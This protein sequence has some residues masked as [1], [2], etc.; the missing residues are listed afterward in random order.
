MYFKITIINWLCWHTWHT[1]LKIVIFFKTKNLARNV[2]LFSIFTTLFNV[3]LNRRQLYFPICS[4][5]QSVLI[6]H[7]MQSLEKST[8]TPAREWKR[9]G[10]IMSSIIVKIVLTC[11]L[12][13]MVF[14]R[15]S[16]GPWNILWEFL[17]EISSKEFVLC[18]KQSSNIVKL[19][20]K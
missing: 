19:I 20:D 10:Q 9:K 11:R 18:G 6:S 3:W 2:A 7:V 4:C 1:L 16:G 12:S 5:I 15:N 13:W 14:L 8:L 17:P